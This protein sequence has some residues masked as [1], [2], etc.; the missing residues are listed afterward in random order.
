MKFYSF[1]PVIILFVLSLFSF[2]N[3]VMSG[4]ISKSQKQELIRFARDMGSKNIKYA[5]KWHPPDQSSAWVMDC[6][7]TAR[8]IYQ[9]FFHFNLPRTSLDQY[10]LA[11]KNGNFHSAVETESG[12]DSSKLANE[13][14]TGDILFWE[15]TYNVNRNPPI[16]HVMVYL[17]KNKS[18]R[19]K[20]FGAG[21]KGTGE[22]TTDGGLDVY[23]FDPNRKMGC[24]RDSSGNCLIDSKF[25]GYARFLN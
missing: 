9:R 5:E 2:S 23:V 20:M 18:N 21:S 15:N 7:N 25:L 3:D 16:S 17:G 12:I 1:L 22:Q 8:Y 11:V 14:R 19:M 24:V 4:G 13:L 10:E 6:S